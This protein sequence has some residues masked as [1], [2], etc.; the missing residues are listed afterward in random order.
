MISGTGHSFWEFRSNLMNR[1]STFD[2][3]QD[4]ER[5]VTIEGY[6]FDAEVRELEKWPFTTYDQSD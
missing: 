5:R 3:I 2:T 1:S 4:E 6:V